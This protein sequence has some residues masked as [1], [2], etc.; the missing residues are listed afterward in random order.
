MNR[1]VLFSE[2]ESIVGDARTSFYFYKD[3]KNRLKQ[4]YC[5]QLCKWYRNKGLVFSILVHYSSTIDY[6]I[7]LKS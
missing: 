7:G 3:E 1:L 2:G 4:Y 6:R 5:L